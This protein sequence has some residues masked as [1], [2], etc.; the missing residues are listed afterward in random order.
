MSPKHPS[1]IL[2]GNHK[3]SVC[4][5][6]NLLLG[7]KIGPCFGCPV[8]HALTYMGTCNEIL[9]SVLKLTFLWI[10]VFTSSFLDSILSNVYVSEEL[11]WLKPV[12]NLTTPTESCHRNFPMR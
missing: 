9:C 11:R 2:Q 4:N 7:R 12:K 5:G 3:L 10:S 6:L 8:Y 1:C